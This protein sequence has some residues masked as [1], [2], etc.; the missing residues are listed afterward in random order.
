MRY[1][2][3]FLILIMLI[4]GCSNSSQ[5]SSV[6][7]DKVREY[8]NAL[9]NRE[10]YAQSITE[11]QRYLDL[12]DVDAAQQANILFIMA[13]TQ[14]DRLHDYPNAMALYLKVKHVY[15]ESNLSREVDKKI[16]ACLER[17]DRSAD[18]KQA[19]DEATSLDPEQVR[20]SRPGTVIARI[21]EREF[22]SGDLNFQ[23]GQMPDYMKDQFKSRE[24]KIQLLQQMVA[25]DLFFDAAKRQGL[26]SDNEVIEGAFQAKKSLMVQKYLQHEIAGRVNI[27]PD[28]VQDYYK[29]NTDKYA[30]KNE[31]G[32]VKRQKS[33]QEVQQQVAEDLAMEK[34][35]RAYEDLL[36]QIMQAEKVQI[37]SDLVE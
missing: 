32:T 4:M 26:D 12:Y 17:L 15:P 9:Y 3:L 11:Y 24:A 8:A 34:Q 13:N 2:G 35:Q 37:Y 22:T 27:T 5:K 23:L 36:Q 25:T 14:F 10:L 20:E 28:H 6:D 21:G 1:K 33:F 7:G 16:V 29:A 31:D 18:A 30:E 19:L